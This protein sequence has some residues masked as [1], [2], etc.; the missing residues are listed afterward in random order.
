MSIY[1]D[2][3][4]FRTTNCCTRRTNVS[5]LAWSAVIRSNALTVQTKLRTYWRAVRTICIGAQFISLTAIYRYWR[6]WIIHSWP[7][8]SFLQ[9]AIATEIG[10]GFFYNTNRCV[11]TE[12]AAKSS[13]NCRTWSTVGCTHDSYEITPWHNWKSVLLAPL[14]KC[15]PWSAITRLSFWL[16]KIKQGY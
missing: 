3:L 16:L 5:G 6:R 9:N 2:Q 13:E 1:R 7:I 8:C 12:I 11:L 4:T 10:C 15:W 14:R